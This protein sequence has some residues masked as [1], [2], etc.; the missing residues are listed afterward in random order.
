MSNLIVSAI[1]QVNS[2][3]AQIADDKTTSTGTTMNESGRTFKSTRQTREELSES[4]EV[5]NLIDRATIL[6][7][8]ISWIMLVSSLTDSSQSALTR[9]SDAIEM[10]TS[11][12]P[13]YSLH[14]INVAY[15]CNISC[16]SA[17][18]IAGTLVIPVGFFA[19]YLRR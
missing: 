6:G 11:A 2:T 18:I 12:T 16:I 8:V 19:R 7:I 5:S 17:Y 15:W 3:E 14:I 13:G 1:I 10:A 4:H 9:M